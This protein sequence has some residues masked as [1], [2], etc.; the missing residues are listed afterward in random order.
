M[1]MRPYQQMVSL[2]LLSAFGCQ[3]ESVTVSPTAVSSPTPPTVAAT[4]ASA[5]NFRIKKMVVDGYTAG[6]GPLFVTTYFDYIQGRTLKQAV[7]P[8]TSPNATE[9]TNEYSYDNQ[10]RLDSYR[11]RYARPNLDGSVGELNTFT[12]KE[13]TVEQSFARL[14]ADGQKMPSLESNA[15]DIYR[16]N[17]GGQITEWVQEGI[18]RYGQLTRARYVYTYENGNVVKATYLDANDRVEFT[19][20]YQY[21]DKQNPFYGWMYTLSPVLRSSKNNVVSAQIDNGTPLKTEYTYNANGL[22]LTK[23]DVTKGTVLTYEYEAF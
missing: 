2:L 4:P 22:P 21:D 23:K 5:A 3:T 20:N 12:F 7:I 9:L 6:L 10:G 17:A 11:V 8:P 14:Q 16:T 1:L 18:I 19:L 13:N 15:R